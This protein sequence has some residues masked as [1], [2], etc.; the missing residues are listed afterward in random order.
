MLG[1]SFAIPA[2]SIDKFNL[3][4]SILSALLA[5]LQNCSFYKQTALPHSRDVIGLQPSLS[6]TGAAVCNAGPDYR[7]SLPAAFSP[8]CHFNSFCD[9]VV[10]HTGTI[11]G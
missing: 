7:S 6:Q 3:Q 10:N 5:F 11:S 8:L 2:G 1:I 9:S 4:V